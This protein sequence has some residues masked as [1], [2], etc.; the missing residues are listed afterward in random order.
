MRPH[1]YEIIFTGRAGA[2][3][4]EEFGDCEVTVGADATTLRANLPDQAA[5]YGLLNRMGAF[6]L[7]LTQVRIV[8]GGETASTTA[9][10][11]EAASA[12]GIPP[13]PARH[14]RP[15]AR[16]PPRGDAEGTLGHHAFC[17]GR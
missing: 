10:P 7:E 6:A 11:M 4:R 2:A 13:A 1:V 17:S 15:P 5:L 12:A 16:I 8:P 14:G 9:Q 3:L